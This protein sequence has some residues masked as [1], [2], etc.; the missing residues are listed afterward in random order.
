MPGA[1]V[2]AEPLDSPVARRLIA[3]LNAELSRDYPPAQRFHS[4]A[5][6]EVAEGAGAFL[7]VWL[8]GAPA[9]CG[10]VRMLA[11]D[12]AELKRMYVVPDARGRGLSRAIL[13]ALED[14]AAALGATRV[15]LETG[16]KAR[17]ALALY[18]SAGYVRIPCFG[19]YAA[20]PTSICFEKRLTVSADAG[21]PA[22]R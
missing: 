15:V 18:E 11:P 4:L 2:R 1:Q 13:R 20:S 12:V 7:V 10:A 3:G 9:G 8:D 5:A 19:A 21:D 14:R 17:A 16:D 22:G 6:E